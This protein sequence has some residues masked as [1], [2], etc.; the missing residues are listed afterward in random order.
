MQIQQRIVKIFKKENSL[1]LE[2]NMVT[3]A[4][5]LWQINLGLSQDFKNL[6]YKLNSEFTNWLEK[7]KNKC[8]KS[9]QWNIF[10][11]VLNVLHNLTLC[12]LDLKV[13]VSGPKS[14]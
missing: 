2:E 3:S 13:V 12:L 9:T 1:F 4:Q 11:K 7:K 5:L 6:K 10:G 8:L 14:I